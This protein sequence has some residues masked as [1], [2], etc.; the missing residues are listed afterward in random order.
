MAALAL[1]RY[2][3]MM[4]AIT[5]YTDHAVEALPR[6]AVL[7]RTHAHLTLA[8]AYVSDREYDQAATLTLTTL[9]SVPREH[10]QPVLF[11]RAHG[12]LKRVRMRAGHSTAATRL[13][14]GLREYGE[15]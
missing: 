10:R 3:G 4:G 8:D 13:A 7:L 14:E 11:G 15:G 9:R 12:L 6:S 2:G 5:N 1:S